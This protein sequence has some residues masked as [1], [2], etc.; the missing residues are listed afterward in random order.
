MVVVLDQWTKFLVITNLTIHQSH[1][2]IKDILH[3]TLVYNTGAAFGIFKGKAVLFTFVAAA[4]S[5][6][7]IIFYKLKKVKNRIVEF[8]LGLILGG[9][10]SN[11]IDRLRFG[12]VLDFIDFRIWPVFNLADSAITL[13]VALIIC[14]IFM[15]ERA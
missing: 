15:T 4:A 6:G 3:I 14:F 10:I 5:I 8:S 9:A 12:Y 2:I 13:G 1:N 11:L 7:I